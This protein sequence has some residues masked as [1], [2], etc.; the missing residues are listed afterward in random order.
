MDVQSIAKM[1]NTIQLDIFSHFKL[2]KILQTAT[3]TNMTLG[4]NDWLVANVDM[5]GFYRVNYDS[6]NWDRLLTKLSSK[7]QVQH[8]IYMFIMFTSAVLLNDY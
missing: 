1:M 4:A 3:N 5:K 8:C 6:E 7:H 2:K